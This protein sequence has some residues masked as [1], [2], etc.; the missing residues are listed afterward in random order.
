MAVHYP[1]DINIFACVCIDY[2]PA[3][4][5]DLAILKYATNKLNG[6][7]I[8]SA[9]HEKTLRVVMQLEQ[10]IGKEIVWVRG[11]SFDQI[12]DEAGCLPTWNRRFCTTD[13]KILPMFEYLYPKY[14]KTIHNIGFRGDE[15]TRIKNGIDR[16]IKYPMSC[17]NFGEHFMNWE[18]VDWQQKNYPLRKTFHFEIRKFWNEKH[19][20]F[21]FPFDSNCRGCHHKPSELIK[22]NWLETPEILEWFAMQERKGKYNTWHDDCIPYAKVFKTEFP[23]LFS[24]LSD[25]TMCDSGGCTD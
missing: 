8:A 17:K 1:T 4:P 18:E 13:M 7:F 11:K 16:T 2:E 10:L 6:N 25:F 5:K 14:G 22:Q 19:P 23:N 3:K 12:V 24:E 20:E 9:E 15:P 21:D